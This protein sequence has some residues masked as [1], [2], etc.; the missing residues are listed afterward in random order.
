MVL[1]TPQFGVTV[2]RRS[3]AQVIMAAAEA[4]TGE[5]QTRAKG[6]F[7]APISALRLPLQGA[8]G[9]TAFPCL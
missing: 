8:T 6:A 2:T 9:S 1:V 7:L 3:T 5:I 4:H